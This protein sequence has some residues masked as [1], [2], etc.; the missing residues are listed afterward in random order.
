MRCTKCI[1]QQLSY[2]N[3]HK[4]IEFNFDGIETEEKYAHTT[5]N[6]NAQIGKEFKKSGN[7]WNHR[8]NM[9]HCHWTMQYKIKWMNQKRANQPDSRNHQNYRWMKKNNRSSVSFKGEKQ[10]KHYNI[11]TQNSINNKPRNGVNKINMYKAREREIEIKRKQNNKAQSIECEMNAHMT[12][13]ALYASM[14]LYMD[15]FI[16]LKFN[17]PKSQS[18]SDWFSHKRKHTH[19]HAALPNANSYSQQI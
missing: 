3:S 19:T 5:Q 4:W 14:Y 12:W 10:K 15:R 9:V 2:R 6:C 11:C 13:V 18:I 1:C 16:V 17:M 8:K 7:V